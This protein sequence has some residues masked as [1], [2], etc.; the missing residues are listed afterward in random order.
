MND[1]NRSLPA[2][3]GVELLALPGAVDLD[4]AATGA[5]DFQETAEIMAGLDRVIC[6]D[7]AA[8]HLAGALGRPVSILLPWRNADWRWMR[9]RTDSP[10]YPTARLY[11]Q[12]VDGDWR[13]P[14][15]LVRRDLE[16]AGLS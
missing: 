3:L 9:E 16:R 15:D 11:R 5:I 6:V 12:P 14:L 1:Q 8:A 2:E 10:W 7:T 4:P 13:T